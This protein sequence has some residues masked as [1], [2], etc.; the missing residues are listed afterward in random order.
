MK[1]SLF[2]IVLLLIPVISI[3]QQNAVPPCS[4]EE[5]SQFDFWIGEWS[6]TWSDTLHGSNSITKPFDQCV[7]MENF[8]SHPSGQFKGMSV[9]TYSIQEKKWKQTWV[10]NSG[11]YLDFTGGMVADSM[12]LSREAIGKEG[13][14]LLQRMIWYNITDK[15]F[16]WDWQRS[17]DDGKSWKTNWQIAYQRK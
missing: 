5:F 17:D 7:V 13:N 16:D 11:G 2:V 14:K 9:S 3:A 8:D 10:D 12:I 1:K 15:S 4:A 6:L